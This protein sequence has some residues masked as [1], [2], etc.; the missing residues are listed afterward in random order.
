MQ[1]SNLAALRGTA[2]GSV[3]KVEATLIACTVIALGMNHQCAAAE[4]PRQWFKLTPCHV[5]EVQEQ[6]RCGVYPV[7][8][9]RQT[10]RGRKLPLKVIVL[11]ARGTEAKEAPIFYLAGGPGETNTD[12]AKVYS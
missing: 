4:P 11:P 12:F 2:S 6:L 10:G 8:E 1:A 5:P 7:F 3:S 9:N